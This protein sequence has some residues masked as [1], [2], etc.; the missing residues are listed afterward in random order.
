MA[1]KKNYTRKIAQ[2]NYYVVAYNQLK[3][4]EVMAHNLF[5]QQIQQKKANENNLHK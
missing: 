1:K 4:I 5:N 2:I 3:R